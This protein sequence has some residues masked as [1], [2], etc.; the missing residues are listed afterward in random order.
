MDPQRHCHF[1][2]FLYL[3]FSNG[4][5]HIYSDFWTRSYTLE[6]DTITLTMTLYRRT[7]YLHIRLIGQNSNKLFHWICKQKKHLIVQKKMV[8]VI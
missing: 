3:S 6:E 5:R 8:N 2:E 1:W 7:F 4:K